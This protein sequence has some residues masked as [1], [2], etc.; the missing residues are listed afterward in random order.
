MFNGEAGKTESYYIDSFIQF[1]HKL[2][3]DLQL[4]GLKKYGLEEKNLDIICRN[5]EIKNNPVK[6]AEEDLDEILIS[7]L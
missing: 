5:T 4:S 3:D 6:L 7:R 2:T 1:L